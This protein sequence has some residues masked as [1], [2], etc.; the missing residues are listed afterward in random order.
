MRTLDAARSNSTCTVALTIPS[1]LI[2]E[3][4]IRAE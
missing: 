3:T 4:G 1:A 2:A